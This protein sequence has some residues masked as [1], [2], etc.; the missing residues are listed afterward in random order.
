M[1]MHYVGG[2]KKLASKSSRTQRWKLL[3]IYI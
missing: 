3:S 2:F 1:Q